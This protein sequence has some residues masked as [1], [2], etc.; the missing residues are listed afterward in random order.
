MA[1][2]YGKNRPRPPLRPSPSQL[3]G[4]VTP[5]REKYHAE[6]LS[7]SIKKNYRHFSRRYR[8]A[9]IECFRLYDWDTAEIR[10]VVRLVCRTPGSRG[11]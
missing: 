3:K 2:S 6:I 5:E 10:I 1:M 7:N 11:I 9:G 8:K 4:V